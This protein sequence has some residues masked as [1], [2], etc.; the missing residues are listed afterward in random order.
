LPVIW[1]ETT[2]GKK[3]PVDVKPVLNGQ[4]EVEEGIAK[5][6]GG[7][8]NGFGYTSHFETCP[9]ADSWRSKR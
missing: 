8:H 5:Y 4:F 9:D 7:K 2:K 3:M 1:T 6:I